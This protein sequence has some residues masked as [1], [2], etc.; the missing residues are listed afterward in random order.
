M[1]FRDFLN[2]YMNKGIVV[3]GE[4]SHATQCHATC[5]YILFPREVM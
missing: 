3:V 4:H 1:F 5:T 2:S